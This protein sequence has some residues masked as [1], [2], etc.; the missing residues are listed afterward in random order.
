MGR[1]C[2]INNN[3]VHASHPVKIYLDADYQN[4]EDNHKCGVKKYFD[5]I[6][7]N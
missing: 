3:P 2:R 7:K 5:L 4:G 1:T 6:E